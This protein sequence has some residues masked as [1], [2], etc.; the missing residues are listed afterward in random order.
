MPKIYAA[1][2]QL[3]AAD[4]NAVVKTAGLYA[5]SSAGSDTY[6]I[7]TSPVSGAYAAGDVFRFKADVAN[8]GACTLNVSGLG[9]VTIKR[10]DNSGAKIDLITGDIIAGQFVEV[11]YD[12]DGH[13]LM[14]NP[15]ATRGLNTWSSA[16]TGASTQATADGFI[17][18]FV[19]FTSGGISAST[20]KT[21]SA[22][23]PTVIRAQI[24]VGDTSDQKSFCVPVK[25]ND[26]Y[27]ITVG[28][29]QNL[30]AYFMSLTT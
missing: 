29:N 6:A 17:V 22:N 25:K 11:I 28:T 18:G 9:A 26:Y 24:L 15:P 19:T 10:H 13:F 12:S 4:Y 21:D 8:T 30:T 3:T 2:D 27:L 14:L 16:T 7:T 5:A 1:G 23:P 20:I